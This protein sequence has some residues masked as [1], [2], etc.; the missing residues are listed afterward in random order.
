MIECLNEGLGYVR[1]GQDEIFG[2]LLGSFI[3]FFFRP[4][5]VTVLSKVLLFVN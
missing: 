4:R 3:S 2:I 5:G 1:V